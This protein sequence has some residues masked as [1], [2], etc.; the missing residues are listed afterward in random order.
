[1]KAVKLTED[2]NTHNEHVKN[3]FKSSLLLIDSY[4]D[5]NLKGRFYNP[6][7]DE[8]QQFDNVMQLILIAEALYDTMSYPQCFN[9][10]RK[11]WDNKVNQY[12]PAVETKTENPP[13]GKLA[14][15]NLKVVFRQNASWQGYLTWLDQG[16]EE[17]FRSFL[18]LLKLIDDALTK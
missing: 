8:E 14:T 16:K 9:E 13:E 2:K 10:P 11:F 17:S 12:E 1:M 5:K 6:Y 15:F 4:K 18:E 3:E 7:L